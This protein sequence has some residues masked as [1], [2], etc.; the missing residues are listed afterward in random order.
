MGE[1]KS[2]LDLVMERTRHL[3][4][5]AEEKEEQRRED[6]AKRL[7]GFLQQYADGALN[8]DALWDRMAALETETGVTDRK[9]SVTAVIQRIDP[10]RDNARWR[11]LLDRLVPDLGPRLQEILAA[12][13]EDR[14]ALWQTGQEQVRDRLAREHAITGSAVVPNPRRDPA[15]QQYLKSLGN[16]TTDKI[17]RLMQEMV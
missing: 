2:T 14:A 9:L 1:I 16:E 7:Q 13:K 6:F 15:M 8:T 12:Y 17:A 11:A 10:D 5:S 3:S 4:L